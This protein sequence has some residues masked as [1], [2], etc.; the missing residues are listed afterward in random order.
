MIFHC[1]GDAMEYLQDPRID[2]FIKANLSHL[3]MDDGDC[4][5]IVSLL[6]K[7]LWLVGNAFEICR[8]LQALEFRIY[9]RHDNPA[10]VAAARDLITDWRALAANCTY[11]AGHGNPITLTERIRPDSD[12]ASED[13]IDRL[14]CN[15]HDIRIVETHAT[16]AGGM[17]TMSNSPTIMLS[18]CNML[19][20]KNGHSEPVLGDAKE[21]VERRKVRVGAIRQSSVDYDTDTRCP[22]RMEVQFMKDLD[23]S[24]RMA[25]EAAKRGVGRHAWSATRMSDPTPMITST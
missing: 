1:S 9:G 8:A 19:V 24:L 23:D 5:C 15:D 20:D 4:Q 2:P 7:H 13:A 12:E 17:T 16:Y 10:V 14:L 18:C 3:A 21:A 25:R 22:D 6:Q 11:N